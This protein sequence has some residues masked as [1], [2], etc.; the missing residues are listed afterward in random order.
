MAKRDKSLHERMSVHFAGKVDIFAHERLRNLLYRHLLVASI[1]R[2][3]SGCPLRPLKHH[4]FVGRS[5]LVSPEV[6]RE[7]QSHGLRRLE[8]AEYIAR[9]YSASL[10]ACTEFT[11]QR[12]A[13]ASHDPG[14]FAVYMQGKQ[15][16]VK[17]HA[18]TLLT[19]LKNN[20][21]LSTDTIAVIG[22]TKQMFQ[23]P[24]GNIG[25]R[26]LERSLAERL[27]ALIGSIKLPEVRAEQPGKKKGKGAMRA[28]AIRAVLHMWLEVGGSA[29][30]FQRAGSDG[31]SCGAFN[32]FAVKVLEIFGINHHNLETF[33]RDAVA[34][35]EDIPGSHLERLR[36]QYRVT[37]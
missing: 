28:E 24:D 29:P 30:K 31:P 6:W 14:E 16:E 27:T 25:S 3:S 33:V 22:D 2:L 9:R 4:H 18:E 37:H 26:T 10:T 23:L 17:Y 34:L 15:A 12:L 35:F 20:R 8:C 1:Q 19:L 5:G 21:L 11:A 36:N 13:D 7:M 32:D